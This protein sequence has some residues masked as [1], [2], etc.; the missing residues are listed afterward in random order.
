MRSERILFRQRHCSLGVAFLLSCYANAA[1]VGGI[2]DDRRR[3][4]SITPDRHRPT[5]TDRTPD[6]RPQLQP[7]HRELATDECTSDQQLFKF[8]FQTDSYG[9]ETSWFVRAQESGS[10]VGYGPPPG[11]AYGDFTLYSF[12]YCL[13]VGSTYTLAVED[14]FGDG[15]CCSRGHGGYEYSLGGA[16]IYSTSLLDTFNEYV[17]HTFTVEAQYTPAPTKDPS[18]EAAVE[19]ECVPNPEECGC[20]DVDQV[21]Y[22]GTISTTEGGLACQAWGDGNSYSAAS[23]PDDDLTSNLC[24][25]PDGGQPW[26]FTTDPDETWGYCRVPACPMV[27]KTQTQTTSPPTKSGSVLTTPRPSTNGAPKTPRPTASPTRRPNLSP[28][29]SPTKLPTT[30]PTLRPTTKPTPGYGVYNP[31]NGCYG[32]DV[33]ISVEAKAD[34][35]STDTDWKLLHPNGTHLFHQPE[36]SFGEFE[37]KASEFCVPHGNYT[38]IIKD[39]YGDG[40]CCRYGRGFFKVKLDGREVLNGGSFN[41]NVTAKLLVGY[42]P[43]GDMT[44]REHQYLEAH[45]VRRK[46]WHERYNVTY[47]PLVYSPELAARTQ[48][49]AEELLHSCGVVGIEHEDHNPFGENL[50]KNTGNAQTWGQL[51]PPDNIVNRWVD[52]EIGLNYPSNGHLTQCL[53]RASKYLGCG[54]AAKP[55][56]GG[57]CRIQVCRYAR[58]GNCDMKRHNATYG[59]NWL[60]PMLKDFTRCGPHCPLGGCL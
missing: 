10:Y 1:A 31:V 36:G 8:V 40:M 50:A 29:T 45:N 33:K 22:R 24:R 44:E 7:A 52:F 38:F 21:D 4:K 27:V 42:D 5:S 57:M 59:E 13:S 16:R 15:M 18:E 34:E 2:R 41:E 35:Y 39:K 60:E 46:D 6:R 26:C 51:Y 14:N 23:H 58:A 43:D 3:R 49:W 55:F 32:G 9:R 25:A 11:V 47:V 53:W 12:S 19:M 20:E 56:R 54:E 37:Y 30:P 48:L 28:T 17:E